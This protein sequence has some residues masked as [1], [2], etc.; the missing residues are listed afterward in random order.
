[1]TSFR[2]L[3]ATHGNGPKKPRTSQKLTSQSQKNIEAPFLCLQSA[4]VFKI[5]RSSTSQQWPPR[6]SLQR[7]R[8]SSRSVR[9]LRGLSLPAPHHGTHTPVSC[10]QQVP[11]SLAK[12]WTSPLLSC[13]FSH[14]FSM[15]LRN[16]IF[17]QGVG[18][19]AQSDTVHDSPRAEN[20]MENLDAKI[21]C[22][23]IVTHRILDDLK[24]YA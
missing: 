16:S 18:L 15:K 13:F 14:F 11:Q 10:P 1:M 19:P 9:I 6:D 3:K 21:D 24:A 2:D 7:F 4:Q 23:P 20:E 22:D 12:A 8:G 17:S 5:H